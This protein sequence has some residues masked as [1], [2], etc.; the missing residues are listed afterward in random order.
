MKKISLMS[1]TAL[2][3]AAS[4]ASLA[5]EQLDNLVI[6]ASGFE[7]ETTEAPASISVIT[8]EDI[9]KGA[10]RD[11][12][13]AIES[14]PG[15][16]L[17]SSFGGQT[18]QIRGLGADYTLIMVD[19]R[20]QNSRES[21]AKE[22]QGFEQEFMPPLS[23]IERIEIVRGPMSTLYGSSAMGGAINII[24]K[25]HTNE[26]HG[27]IRSE[28]VIAEGSKFNNRN[29]NSISL[30]GP[31]I[32]DKLSLQLNTEYFEQEEDEIIGGNVEKNTESYRAK[33]S[34]SPNDDHTFALDVSRTEIER[35][36]TTTGYDAKFGSFQENEKESL[37]LTHE[38]NYGSIEESSYLQIDSVDNITGESKVSNTILD[39]N[40]TLPSDD[41]I[42]TIGGNYTQ[43]ELE[44][45]D[46]SSNVTNDQVALYAEDEWGIT[47]NFA[48][49]IGLRADKNEN[50][51]EHLSPRLYGVFS[52][53]DQWTLKGG[54]S[55]GYKTPKIR[56]LS[57]DWGVIGRDSN[58]TVGNPNL[59]PESS[60]SKEIGISYN[61]NRTLTSITLFE[62]KFKDQISRVDCTTVDFCENTNNRTYVNVNKAETKGLELSTKYLITNR[63]TTTLSYTYMDSEQLSGS[64]K[65][66]PLTNTPKHVGTAS[67]NWSVLENMNTWVNYQYHGK[68]NNEDEPTPAYE[69]VDIGGKYQI[70]SNLSVSLGINNLLGEEF[71][72]DVFGY[73]EP[74][75]RYW[76]ALDASF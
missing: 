42:L 24:T 75:R 39:S 74:T 72:Y 70:N 59:K 51:D 11:L 41:H 21:Q 25:K 23:M 53:S 66:E 31:I 50:F 32:S 7:Q 22:S 10:Y 28:L 46:N 27:N 69:L 18:I 1:M 33:V 20:P 43:S 19:G 30:S 61:D 35:I 60:V 4:N 3:V 64:S 67:V 56:Q 48:L 29:K 76:V 2:A 6:T 52:F 17:V 73:T 37:A 36:S 13:E 40:W 14:V 47:D 65:G 44:G 15:V 55:T 34:F 62:N 45:S 8:A 63:L 68:E 9:E 57:S 26:W 58:Y 12:A 54:I 5:E 49:T 16:Q 71:D 38:G